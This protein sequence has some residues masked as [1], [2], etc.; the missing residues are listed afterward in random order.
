MKEFPKNA[1]KKDR[2]SARR[3][4]RFHPADPLFIEAHMMKHLEDSIVLDR[5]KSLCKIKL[6]NHNFLP[7]LLTLMEVLESPS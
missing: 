5:V 3:K 2:R 7:G 6:E 4:N 1:I